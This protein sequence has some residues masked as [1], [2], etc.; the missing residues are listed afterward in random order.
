MVRIKPMSYTTFR[1]PLFEL[2]H[3]IHSNN[4]IWHHPYFILF[5]NLYLANIFVSFQ[6]AREFNVFEDLS[7]FT[8][9]YFHCLSLINLVVH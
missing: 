5:L 9:V 8:T 6:D 3:K 7:Y 2:K 4:G 1:I